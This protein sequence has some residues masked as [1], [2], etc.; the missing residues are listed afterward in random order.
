[1]GA[2]MSESPF[3]S[4]TDDSV[5]VRVQMLSELEEII[6]YKDHADQP[7]R[8]ETQRKTWR[9]RLAHTTVDE[10]KVRLDGCQKDVEVWQRILQVRSLV[11][12]PNEDTET[13]IDFADLCV[14]SDRLNLAEKTLTSLVGSSY[15]AMDP[16][17]SQWPFDRIGT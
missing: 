9:N 17:A 1:M 16:E 8:Q 3:L 6:S 5:V 15:N 10:L 12:T 7:D 4:S 14:Q 11:L 13:W 2:P